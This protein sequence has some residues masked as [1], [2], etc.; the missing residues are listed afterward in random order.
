MDS[1]LRTRVNGYGAPFDRSEFVY[2]QRMRKTYES[3]KEHS[4]DVEELSEL[5]FFLAIILE[6]PDLKQY[7]NAIEKKIEDF[8]RLRFIMKIAP[9]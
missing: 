9:T 6:D 7:M 5:K 2:L 1:C 4:F 3:L 8:D